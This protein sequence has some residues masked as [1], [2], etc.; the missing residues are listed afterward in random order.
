MNIDL[1]F[2]LVA[3]VI[4]SGLIWL[5]D[6]VFFARKRQARTSFDQKVKLPI[7]VDYARSFFPLL[8]IVLII[9]SFIFQP[10]KVPSGSLMPTIMAGD[11]IAVNMGAYGLRLP[12]THTKIL[13]TGKLHRG[14]IVLFR[15]PANPQ[16]VN[17]IK[18]LIGLPGDTISYVNKVLYI[19]GKEMTQTPQGDTT[20]YDCATGQT[21]CTV[22]KI[23]ED[24]D[25]VKHNILVYPNIP[26]RNFYNLKVPA[27]EYFMM[28]DNRDN[29]DDSRYW[30]FVKD[31]AII[32]KALFIFFSWDSYAGHARWERMFAAIH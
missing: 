9:R 8:L 30:G 12:L 10:F 11:Y 27:G 16:H 19:N 23:Q 4:I 5:A 24:L 14:D 31:D 26:S 18:R 17:Y 7:A 32:G 22:K 15:W 3:L 2:I 20:D 29:S 1:P 28:G 6:S 25:G 21:I 13:N